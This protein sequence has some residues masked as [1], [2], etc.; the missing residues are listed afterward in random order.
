LAN[1]QALSK[2]GTEQQNL[3]QQAVN[4]Q[5]NEYLRQ[6]KY[7]QEMIKLQSDALSKLPI[8]TKNELTAQKSFVQGAVGSAD[9]V[10]G[11]IDKMQKQKMTPAAISKYINDLTKTNPKATGG[12]TLDDNG[13]LVYPSAPDGGTPYSDTGELQRGW[14]Y[15]EDNNPVWVGKDYIDPTIDPNS[16]YY[17]PIDTDFGEYSSST[18]NV[19]GFDSLDI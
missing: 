1:L 12:I 14:G 17:Q 19:D 6:L 18:N 3:D 16:P 11:L 4:A 10:L 15:D 13:N 9:T 7:P 8:T 2:A 5:Y